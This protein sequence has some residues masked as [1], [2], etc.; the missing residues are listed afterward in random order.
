VIVMK[1]AMVKSPARRSSRRG[2][3]LLLAAVGL[4]VWQAWTGYRDVCRRRANAA[5]PAA[6]PPAL[7]RWEGEGGQPLPESPAP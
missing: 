7:Q 3:G 4:M 2:N 5:R 6:K 1:H